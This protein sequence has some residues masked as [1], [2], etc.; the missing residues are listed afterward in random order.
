MKNIDKITKVVRG[1]TSFR[2]LFDLLFFLLVV[3]TSWWVSFP[4]AIAGQIIFKNYYELFFAGLWIDAVQW[5]GV[6]YSIPFFFS[7]A[8]IVLFL[9]V[10][11]IRTYIQI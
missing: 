6:F 7:L 11:K 5:N 1:K 9:G 4:V 2:I 3:F 10:G 8:S